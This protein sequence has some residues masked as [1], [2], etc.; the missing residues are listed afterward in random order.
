MKKYTQVYENNKKHLGW[1]TNVLQ[2]EKQ[3]DYCGYNMISQFIRFTDI[4]WSKW[5]WKMGDWTVQ[6]VSDW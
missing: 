5:M 6:W 4:V 2:L 1:E 3:V